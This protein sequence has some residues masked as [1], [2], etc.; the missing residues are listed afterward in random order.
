MGQKAGVQ[1]IAGI[2]I[3]GIAGNKE[4]EFKVEAHFLSKLHTINSYFFLKLRLKGTKSRLNSLTLRFLI[5][6]APLPRANLAVKAQFL[7]DYI[8]K[9]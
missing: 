6:R 5:A 4:G 8:Y 2:K 3:Q 9:P 1:G 7:N